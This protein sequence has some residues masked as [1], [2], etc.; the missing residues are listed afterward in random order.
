MGIYDRD[1]YRDEQ[2]EPGIQLGQRT[3]VTN[4]VIVNVALFLLNMFLVVDKGPPNWLTDHLSIT[5]DVFGKPW[6]WWKLITYGFAHAPGNINH[7]FWNMLGLWMFG[8]EVESIYGRREFLRFY[9]AAL[10]A[11]GFVWCAMAQASGHAAAALLGASGAVTAVTLLFVLHFPKRTI[12]LMMVLPVPAWVM[13]VLIVVGNL[14]YIEKAAC[15]QVA[16]DVHL[17]GAAFAICYY[18]FRW[19]L[20][21][22]LPDWP[23]WRRSAARERP[24]LKVHDP[25]E[26]YEEPDEEA[27]RILEKVGRE[28]LEQLSARERRVLEDYS[29][30]MRHKHH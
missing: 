19:N 29:R 7:I 26:S 2:P 9:L 22:W 24:H 21:R 1:Y 16:Y 30:R 27:D 23:Q 4:L 14:L 8:R 13:G 12:L 5:P 25:D 11:G 18:R 10:L 3:V 15:D 20:G 6:L 28:G 17:V